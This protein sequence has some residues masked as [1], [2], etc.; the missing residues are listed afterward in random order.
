[1]RKF[2]LIIL[3]LAVC[4]ML[5][6]CAP[7]APSSETTSTT[8]QPSVTTTEAEPADPFG[9]Y[10]EA[11][12]LKLGGITDPNTAFPSGQSI[13]KN[14]YLDAIKEAFNINV[15]YEWVAAPTDYNTKINLA[16]GSDSLPDAMNVNATQFQTLLKYGQL[17]DITQL[18]DEYASDMLKSFINSGG[19]PLKDMVIIDG[20]M[21]AIPAPTLTAVS[22]DQ[23]WIRQD[24]LDSLGLDAPESIE[25]LRAVAKAFVTQDPDGNNQA[26]TIGILGPT[27]GGVLA[28]VGGN[29]FGL[30]PVFNAFKSF[31]RSWLKDDSNKVVYGSVLPETKQALQLLSEFYRE[32]LIDPELLVRADGFGPVLSGSVGIFFAPWW[33]GYTVAS[34]VMSGTMDW[35]AYL[36]PLANDGEYYSQISAPTSQY[37][38]INKNCENPE[39]AVKIINLLIRDAQ[40]WVDS[41]YE[42]ALPSSNSYPLYNVYDNANEDIFTYLTLKDYLADKITIDDIDFS[43]H[44][45]L[46][47]DM[48]AIKKLKLAPYD[49]Y[50]PEFWDMKHELAANNIPRMLSVMIGV[51]TIVET[52]YNEVYNVYY[53]QTPAMEERYFNLLKMEDET[54]AQIILGQKS[55]DAFDVFVADWYREGGQTILDEIHEIVD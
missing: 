15:E 39:A 21:M 4:L 43:T 52:G 30:D 25:D 28:G 29:L 55:I 6:A 53:G 24:W 8:L 13:E 7:A 2:S 34:P 41:G 46:K 3:L 18:F 48:E 9:Y 40:K 47:N 50:S 32:G 5:N 10:D 31:P 20:K 12:T 23:M 14:Q 49:D 33:M 37:V 35:R 17:M 54:F 51:G 26:D 36:S 22:V 44:K 38:V 11:V 45:L 27:N 1:M 19:Q 16:I 42:A